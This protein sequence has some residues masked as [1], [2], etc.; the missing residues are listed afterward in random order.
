[1]KFGKFNSVEE[2]QKAYAQLE[3]A[4]TK[5]CQQVSE[6]TAK[7]QKTADDDLPWWMDDNHPVDGVPVNPSVA[8]EQNSDTSVADDCK[9][10]G[11]AACSVADNTNAVCADNQN[12]VSDNA[13]EQVN[14][15][16]VAQ[17]A[18]Q[19]VGGEQQNNENAAG[20]NKSESTANDVSKN[21]GGERLN[22][23]SVEQAKQTK[24]AADEARPID[25]A[26][27]AKTNTHCITPEN[28]QENNTN[29][30]NSYMAKPDNA[31]VECGGV[32]TNGTSEASPPFVEDT[33]S[34]EA[35]AVA[36]PDEK[37]NGEVTSNATMQ[38]AIKQ[39]IEQNPQ[40]IAELLA[41]SSPCAPVVM[42][43]GG[44][45]QLAAPNRPKTIKEA[46]T[47]AKK[48]FE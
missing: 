36:V 7:A 27:A 29:N 10:G 44:S 15:A 33:A 2:L 13:A 45:F 11:V 22:S 31:V 37:S 17:V 23:E 34:R 28:T 6:L 19:G 16:S 24:S 25:T 20:E 39:F 47:L 38:A 42:T 3:K 5:K 35:A 9:S 46:S 30:H 18:N 48:L 40:F 26:N 12:A 32:K 43:G 1:M 41:K 14:R 4:F 8:A 21:G